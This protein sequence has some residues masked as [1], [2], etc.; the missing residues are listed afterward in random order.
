MK[1]FIIFLLLYSFAGHAQDSSGV[2]SVYFDAKTNPGTKKNIQIEAQYFHRYTL[3]S[4]GE[5]DFR[6]AAGDQLI[7]DEQG[8]YLEKNRLLSI[9]RTEIRENSAYHL[10]SD[11]LHGVVPNDSVL[12]TRDGEMYYFLIPKKTFLYEVASENTTLFQ[13]RTSN[14][15]LIFSPEGNGALSV[16][17]INFSGTEITL[18]AINLEQ[19]EFDFRTVN[20]KAVKGGSIPLF[21]L[22]PTKTEW[23]AILNH[24]IIYDRYRKV[25]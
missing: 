13:G 16:L 25:D 9:S 12:V 15:Y 1:R 21:I 8:I 14:E 19:Q 6:V 11:Y 23:Q 18:S 22:S 10:N 7:V 24:F 5:L 3:I 20:G 17:M 4:R 2:Y